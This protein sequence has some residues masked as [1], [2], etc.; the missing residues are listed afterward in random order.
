MMTVYAIVNLKNGKRYIGCTSQP[1]VAY[2]GK[3][4]NAALAGSTAK[5]AIYGAIRKYGAESFDCSV[6]KDGLASLDDM[7]AFERQMIAQYDSMNKALGYNLTAGGEGVTQTPEIRRKIGAANSIALRGKKQSL[8]TRLKR[9]ASCREVWKRAGV[10]ERHRTAMLGRKVSTE[11]RERIAAPQ[12]GWQFSMEH[13]AK[14]KAARARQR[15]SNLGRSFSPEWCRAISSAKLGTKHSEATRSKQSRSALLRYS[16]P[17][18][19]KT[20]SEAV[21]KWW[22]GRKA[23]V[24]PSA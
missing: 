11:T 20:T 15:P 21:R 19:R 16:N 23:G 17:D 18:Q 22:A 14:I 10:R 13:R 3:N 9:G 4:I 12:R 6:I 1:L 8:A 24:L 5:P 2:F 7:R